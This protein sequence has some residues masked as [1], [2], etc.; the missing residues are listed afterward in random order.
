M[1]P[2][3][4]GLVDAVVADAHGLHFSSESF[5]GAWAHRTFCAFNIFIT[6]GTTPT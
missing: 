3:R 4:R 6:R 1:R 5:D 2:G